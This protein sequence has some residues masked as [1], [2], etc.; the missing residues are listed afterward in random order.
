MTVYLGPAIPA[1]SDLLLHLHADPPADPARD[2]PAVPDDPAELLPVLGLQLDHAAHSH[3]VNLLE[4]AVSSASYFYFIFS[5]PGDLNLTGWKVGQI[6]QEIV[7]WK[8]NTNIQMI[9]CYYFFNGVSSPILLNV[10]K[11]LAIIS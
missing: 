6:L 1:S 2:V 5:P 4:L 10:L 7:A 9:I 11:D 8:K 3:Q